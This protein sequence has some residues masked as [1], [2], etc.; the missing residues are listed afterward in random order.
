M[1][2]AMMTSTLLKTAPVA[3]VVVSVVVVVGNAP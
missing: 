2:A 3:V 1:N